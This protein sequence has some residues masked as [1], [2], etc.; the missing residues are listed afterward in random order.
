MPRTPRKRV[1]WSR[2]DVKRL[3]SLAGRESAVR[4]A[5]KLRRTVQAVRFKAHTY[6]ISLAPR[7]A[8]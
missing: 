1:P 4:I 3:R 8:R 5:R 7:R 6:Q 2:D